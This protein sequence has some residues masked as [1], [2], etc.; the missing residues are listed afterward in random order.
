MTPQQYKKV[1][2]AEI[3]KI[4]QRID[5]KIL[6]GERYSDDSRRH[7]ELLKK[8]QR[9]HKKEGFLDSNK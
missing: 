7:R 6:R 4:N 5:L 8:L 1:L 2:A 3:R 9:Q